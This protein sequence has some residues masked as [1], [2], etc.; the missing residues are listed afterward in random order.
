MATGKQHDIFSNAK[1][2]VFSLEDEI[3]YNL[4]MSQEKLL[5]LEDEVKYVQDKTHRFV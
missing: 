3:R 4:R 5:S 1:G 2:R